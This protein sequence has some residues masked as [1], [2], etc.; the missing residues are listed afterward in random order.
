METQS[1]S[2]ATMAAAPQEWHWLQTSGAGEVIME[3]TI[4]IHYPPNTQ[5]PPPWQ[6]DWQVIPVLDLPSIPPGAP[7]RAGASRR[8]GG[9]PRPRGLPAVAVVVRRHP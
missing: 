8:L 6:P 2:A 9:G 4:L 5:L 7:G 1:R 3:T